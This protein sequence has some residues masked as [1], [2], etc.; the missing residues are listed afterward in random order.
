MAPSFIESVLQQQ[1]RVWVHTWPAPSPQQI[2]IAKKGQKLGIRYDDSDGTGLVIKIINPG[3][4]YATGSRSPLWSMHASFHF[5][6]NK[7]T[8]MRLLY[9]SYGNA[10]VAILRSKYVLSSQLC[11]RIFPRQAGNPN[12]NSQQLASF[13]RVTRDCAQKARTASWSKIQIDGCL[14]LDLVIFRLLIQRCSEV[15]PDEPV[16]VDSCFQSSVVSCSPESGGCFWFII[17]EVLWDILVIWAVSVPAT[18]NYDSGAAE[19][20]P[21]D[22]IVVTWKKG[23]RKASLDIMV[24]EVAWIRS[25]EQKWWLHFKLRI[26]YI[27]IYTYVCVCVWVCVCVNLYYIYIYHY[28]CILTR[29]FMG[30]N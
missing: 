9:L 21:D 11:N 28:R 19:V 5:G 4:F 16:C 6:D 15:L 22:R 14:A 20:M 1:L 17:H 23:I 24:R 2:D 27:Y 12:N 3:V 7:S 25:N 10:V 13:T 29:R 8:A 18:R 30:S 26:Q